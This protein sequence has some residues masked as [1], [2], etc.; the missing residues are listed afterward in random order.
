MDADP[1]LTSHAGR[2]SRAKG[3]REREKEGS[4]RRFKGCGRSAAPD[5]PALLH[6]SSSSFPSRV[7]LLSPD[8]PLLFFLLRFSQEPSVLR[9]RRCACSCCCCM[10]V[11]ASTCCYA[12]ARSLAIE[13]SEAGLRCW[14]AL[15]RRHCLRITDDASLPSFSHPLVRLSLMP[16]FCCCFDEIQLLMHFSVIR[17]D[18]RQTLTQDAKQSEGETRGAAAGAEASEKSHSAA[19]ELV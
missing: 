17:K 2:E 5:H 18:I 14:T 15:R 6:L 9:N 7:I 3:A 8:V 4:V 11:R 12:L 1:R 19:R 16:C 13:R 10:V